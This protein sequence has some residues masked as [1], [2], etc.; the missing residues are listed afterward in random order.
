[1]GEHSRNGEINARP[2]DF[3]FL[4]PEVSAVKKRRKQVKGGNQY[5]TF[6]EAIFYCLARQIQIGKSRQTSER[7][8]RL[9]A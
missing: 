2:G 1:M 3:S 6:I 5:I 9:S 8:L 7:F 4:R